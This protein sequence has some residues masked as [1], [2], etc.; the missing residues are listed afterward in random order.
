MPAVASTTSS[1]GGSEH[2]HRRGSPVPPARRPGRSSSLRVRSEPVYR[3]DRSGILVRVM[4]FPGLRQCA[5]VRQLRVPAEAPRVMQWLTDP[6][7]R[8]REW[9]RLV[10]TREDIQ[11]SGAGRLPDG[12][13]RFDQVL[14][15]GNLLLR[16]TTEDVVNQEHRIDRAHRAQLA[17]PRMMPLRWVM[18]ERITVE[19][20]GDGTSLTVRVRGRLAGLGRALHLLGYRDTTTARRLTEEASRRGGLPCRWRRGSFHRTSRYRCEPRQRRVDP[21]QITRSSGRA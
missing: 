17:G 20:L 5:A 19:S 8:E 7:R 18:K 10:E 9:R 14:R 11:Q 2:A 6:D 12:G 13:L 15:R 4:L 3:A 1:G 21:L 16:H